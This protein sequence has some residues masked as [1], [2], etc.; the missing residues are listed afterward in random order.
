MKAHADEG[1]RAPDAEHRQVADQ[2]K[3]DVERDNVL[4]LF[5]HCGPP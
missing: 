3:V 2:A 4:G 1:D 5:R